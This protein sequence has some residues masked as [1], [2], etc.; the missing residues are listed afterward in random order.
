M[1]HRDIMSAR[2]GGSQF[3]RIVAVLMLLLF[4]S[5]QLLAMWSAWHHELHDEAG[6][7]EHQCAVTA[8]TGGHIDAAP[9]VAVV[10]A[11]IVS[12]EAHQTFSESPL[13]LTPCRRLA[14]RAPPVLA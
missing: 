9:A 7:A 6:S 2:A 10:S 1:N 8:L 3:S 12:F 5:I 14:G 4:V 13:T 11:P